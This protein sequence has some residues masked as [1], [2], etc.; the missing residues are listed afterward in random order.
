MNPRTPDHPIDPIFVSRWSPRAFEPGTDRL[1]PEARPLLAIVAEQFR[2]TNA[3]KADTEHPD[4]RFDLAVEVR[5]PEGAPRAARFPDTWSLTASQAVAV[6]RALR[7][8]DLPEGDVIAV[9]RG[10]APPTLKPGTLAPPPTGST[11]EF[12]F[13]SRPLKPTD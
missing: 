2:E 6:A 4:G 11:V 5:S 10:P 12:I 1:K 9:G 7:E 3:R 13:L 8:M